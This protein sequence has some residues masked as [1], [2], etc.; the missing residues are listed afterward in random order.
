MNNHIPIHETARERIS[1]AVNKKKK[2]TGAEVTGKQTRQGRAGGFHTEGKQRVKMLESY[3]ER[4]VNALT[5]RVGGSAIPLL[6]G[7]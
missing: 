6:G 2:S 3:P 1:V 4:Y 7:S 5:T